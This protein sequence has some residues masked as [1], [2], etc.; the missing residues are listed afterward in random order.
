M[1]PFDMLPNELLEFVVG[2]VLDGKTNH[3]DYVAT[4]VVQSVRLV[5]RTVCDHLLAARH[6]P[7]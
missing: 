4:P 5:C 7:Y 3:F 6:H 2:H 1:A